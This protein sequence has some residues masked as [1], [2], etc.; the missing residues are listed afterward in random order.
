VEVVVAKRDAD[1][2]FAEV[3]RTGVDPGH[4]LVDRSMPARLTPVRFEYHGESRTKVD[5]L[6]IGEGYAASECGS[7]FQ[8]DGRRMVDALFAL[9][10]FTSHRADFNVWGLCPP[11]RES[12]ISRPSTGVHIDSPL[13][14]TYD[15]FGSERYVLTE[16]NRAFRTVASNAPYEFAAIMVN[17]ATY[18]GGGMYNLF[19]TFAVDNPRANYLFIH[20]FG[21]HFAGLGDEYYTSPVAYQPPARIVEP[22][23]PNLTAL[24]QPAALKWRDLVE[25]G[26][27]VPTPWPKQEFEAHSRTVQARRAALRAERRPESEMSALF[28]E[29]AAFQSRLLGSAPHAGRVGAFQ[30]A[31]YDASAFYRPAID[32]VMFSRDRVPFCPVCQRAIRRV[33]EFHTRQ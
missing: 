3:W 25:P 4:M 14:A 6:V 21:H 20:E 15:F 5:V 12:G 8:R 32:C 28:A 24:L 17:G 2:R 33:I 27:P 22:W 30:G 29:E 16:N 9:E 18:G 26:T 7:K 31:N 13:G 10:P 11:A 19:S 1:N 23:E